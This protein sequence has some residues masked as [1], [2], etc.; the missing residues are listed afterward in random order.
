MAA[1]ESSADILER[2]AS[3]IDERRGGDPGESY[4]AAMLDGDEDRLLKKIGEEAAEVILAAKKGERGELSEE[5][6]DLLFH[7]LLVLARH[8]LGLDDVRAVLV[9]RFGRSGLADKPLRTQ[10]ESG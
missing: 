3:V 10:D 8:D 4:V 2:L 9:A 7:L 6:A 5:A 1:A